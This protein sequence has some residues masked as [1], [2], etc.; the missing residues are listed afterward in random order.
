MG[1]FKRKT[2]VL[3]PQQ[4]EEIYT[5]DFFDMILPST[6]KFL[7]TTTLLGTHIAVCGR[8]VNIPLQRRN[9]QYFLNLPTE[10][11]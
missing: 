7:P 11:V 1:L 8:C 2:K 9:R 3:T 6:I 5:K 10:I 4:S